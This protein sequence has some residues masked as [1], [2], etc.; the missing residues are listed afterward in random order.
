M[1]TS[2]DAFEAMFRAHYDDLLRFAVRRVGPDAAADVVAD[3]FLVAWRRREAIPSDAA[4]LWLFGVAGNVINNERR[5]QL[6][7]TRLLEKAAAEP[8][9]LD[10]ADNTAA[11]AVSAAFDSLAEPDQEVLRLTEWE[12]L[13][14]AEAAVVL[15][16]STAAFR[17][18]LHRARRRLA[19]AVRDTSVEPL[20]SEDVIA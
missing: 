12:Q 17:V 5:G 15:G 1:E 16:C 7:R 6:R 13:S 11:D 9:S 20:P 4:R 10:P 8:P 19:E 18:R 2:R 3:V 14:A